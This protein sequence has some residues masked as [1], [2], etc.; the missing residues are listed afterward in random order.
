[1]ICGDLCTG[2]GVI[3]GFRGTF[4]P[5]LK[6]LRELADVVEKAGGLAPVRC[7]KFS[8]KVRATTSDGVKVLI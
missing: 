7:I 6:F 2:C 1:M 4:E 5:S 8:G 3:D